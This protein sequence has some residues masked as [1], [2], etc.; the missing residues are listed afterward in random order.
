MSKM[1]ELDMAVTLLRDGAKALTSAADALTELFSSKAESPP[2][3][4]PTEPEQPT[5]ETSKPARS[6]TLEEV[7]TVLAEK[8][9]SGHSEEVKA[10]L[11][12]HGVARLSDIDP[13]EYP[14]LLKEAEV[15][16]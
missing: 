7:R 9:R 10:L 2:P 5:T 11:E 8:S 15:I 6:I 16:R 3:E 4:P 13:A 14:A 12:K 1:S